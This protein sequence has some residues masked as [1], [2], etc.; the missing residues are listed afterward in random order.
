MLPV[1]GKQVVATE[2]VCAADEP[3]M[4]CLVRDMCTVNYSRSRITLNLPASTTMCSLYNEVAQH[5]NYVPGTFLLQWER[6]GKDGGDNVDVQEDSKDT[7]FQLGLLPDNKR[8][9]FVINEKNEQPPQSTIQEDEDTV[10]EALA[11][12]ESQATG[13]T[14]DSTSTYGPV[15]GPSPNPSTD[16]STYSYASALI[17]SDTGYVGLVNQAMTCYLNSLL[18]TLYMTPEFR[19]A[20]YK[21][22][23]DGSEEEEARS[24]P[25][26][27]Q[28]LFIQLQTSKKRAVETTD[29]TRSFGWDSSDAW[30]QHD[31]QE[32][33]R[34]MFDALETKWKNTDQKNLINELYQGRL[35]DY[36][37]CLECGSE[38][39]RM[40]AFLDIPLTV[41]PFGA[42]HAY[43]NV[44]EALEAFV[45]PE[46]LNGSNQ[47]FCEKCNK[48]CDAHKGLK[49]V[50]FP[51]LLTMQLKR[52]DFD[53]NTM[54]RIKLNDKM[55]FPEILNLNSFITD[56][57]GT[58]Q[59]KT[60]EEDTLSASGS[61]AEDDAGLG[62]HAGETQDDMVDE[63][64]DI[65][66]NTAVI[67]D[68]NKREQQAKG[69]YMYE[70]F[71]IMIHSGS[72][73]GG[74]YYA[75]IKSFRDGQ[76]YSFN[77]QH[78]TKITY[79]DI[80]KTYGGSG[81]HRGY[82]SGAFASSTNAYMLM[83][84]QIE[85]KR[86][87][88]PIEPPDLPEHIQKLVHK[89]H[90]REEYERRQREMDKAMCK[91]KLFCVHPESKK[92]L[93]G[94][95]EVHKDKTLAEATDIA[96]KMFNLD[97]VI[98][99]DQC[100][101][102]KYDEFHD[103]LERS[104][105]GEEETPMGVLLGGV[106]STY[107]FDLLLETRR[108]DQKFQKYKTGGTTV[109]VHVVDLESE[110]VSPPI[111]VRAYL[112]QTISE[113]KN[114]L[115]QA[116][117]LPA[118]NMRVVFERYYNELRLLTVA[119]KTL[120]AEG[121]MRSNKVFVE[122]SESQDSLLPLPQ[123]KMWYLLD[124]YANTIRVYITLP[125]ESAKL[126]DRMSASK[127]PELEELIDTETEHMRHCSTQ[128]PCTESHETEAAQNGS[129]TPAHDKTSTPQCNMVDSN[130]LSEE[131]EEER[132]CTDEAGITDAATA[133]D[134]AD[135]QTDRTAEWNNSAG[136]PWNSDGSGSN[137]E[138]ETDSCYNSNGGDQDEGGVSGEEA[139][140]EVPPPFHRQ[141]Y[142]FYAE[143]STVPVPVGGD[144]AQEVLIAHLD[145]RISL[146]ALKKELE[147]F[148]GVT[149]EN[150]KVYRS[151]ANNQEFESVRLNENLSQFGDDCKVTIRLGRALRKGEYRV[152]I[153]QLMVND[154]EP[155][156]FLLDWVVAKGMTVLQSKED[157]LPQLRDQ[158]GLDIPLDRCRLRKK[159]WK[160]PGTIFLDWQV[161]E[162]DIPVF[163]NW[164]V[165]L[166]VL[167]EPEAMVSMQ[168]IAVF[169]RRWFPTEYKLGPFQEIIIEGQNV[170]ELKE[171]I[172]E[173][174][175]LPVERVQFAKGRG[176]FPCDVSLLE[177]HTDLEWDPSVQALN[178]WPLYICDDGS[179]LFYR[180][181]EETL[182]ALSDDQRRDLQRKEN[183]R[184][185]KTGSRISYSPRKERALKIY[186][187]NSKSTD[188]R[189]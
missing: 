73:A 64:I 37:R 82:Y 125:S 92:L 97:P 156:K 178:T 86:N 62:N 109:K 121:F 34:V 3:K 61:S 4:L 50:K 60:D 126:R 85:T 45:Q 175:G 153:Y 47:Y 139:E 114:Q 90:D 20:V 30:Q 38:S 179:V 154:P 99:L 11:I 122:C 51:Y 111:T 157:I 152:K 78:V 9:H 145:K 136:G 128:Q 129:Q 103:T 184:L 39:A 115:A 17:K 138:T 127:E 77:D 41:R 79:D 186:T 105:E 185:N 144:P 33:C 72:A 58:I 101:L 52:F 112:N 188:K 76:W 148:V 42:T 166:Q 32:L 81:S 6:G 14:T 181:S 135:T 68:R 180:D 2:M 29:I 44:Q 67:N 162:D 65:E 49:F 130:K 1:E 95:L 15:Y 131:E 35:K 108:P 133:Q 43:G 149:G 120:K 168:Q 87:T 147:P 13:S 40:D 28:K 123:S 134:S 100:R 18:Q 102:V 96:W 174:S 117:G 54:Q 5:A 158:C 177:I 88:L 141:P 91:I 176:T 110:T 161:Y 83:Y 137:G 165:F 119:N 172:A 55:T 23:F 94:R 143:Y 167:E 71:S 106:K 104:Y 80:R 124:R 36:V 24:I 75:Y 66:Q 159:T 151:Y 116:T 142:Y 46:T 189:S 164:E 21:W 12:S 173:V 118:A 16:Y 140:V 170:E 69:P 8:N 107:I 59:S 163:S 74:H 26:Q 19:N 98:A 169:V 48:K 57:T 31:V 146:G 160:N 63:G 10:G 155:C 25:S 22:E 132:T 56:D 187:D 84:R 89:L 183:T 113:F 70:L 7:L 93:E 150:F 171:R 53:Y 182:A 27:L